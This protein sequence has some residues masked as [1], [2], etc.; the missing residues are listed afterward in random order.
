MCLFCLVYFS[1]G[2]FDNLDSEYFNFSGPIGN[3]TSTCF[4]ITVPLLFLSSALL[5]INCQEKATFEFP[6]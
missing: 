5:A 6:F 2:V 1:L 4:E 3:L